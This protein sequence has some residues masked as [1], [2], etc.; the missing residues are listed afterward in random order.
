MVDS[1][2][3][4]WTGMSDGEAQEFHRF[5]IQGLIVF[6]AIAVV[7]HFLVWVWRPWFPGDDGYVSSLAEQVNVAVASLAPFIA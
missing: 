4:G 6:V 7:A 2:K 5:Y 1:G 3:S